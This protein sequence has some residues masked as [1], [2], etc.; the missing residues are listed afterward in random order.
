M[1]KSRVQSYFCYLCQRH[2]NAHDNTSETFINLHNLFFIL[3]DD[4]GVI[5]RKKQRQ[6]KALAGNGCEAVS[7]PIGCWNP[8]VHSISLGEQGTPM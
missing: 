1:H 4:S 7:S 5:Y 8:K 6:E 3:G 2:D